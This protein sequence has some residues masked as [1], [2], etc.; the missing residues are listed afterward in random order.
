MGLTAGSWAVGCGP[1]IS[2][3]L[4][5]CVSGGLGGKE[6]VRPVEIQEDATEEPCV[7]RVFKGLRR[8]KAMTPV[9]PGGWPSL[10][11]CGDL[12]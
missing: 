7:A 3:K 10:R 4:G 6:K 11:G 8:T 5:F 2:V 1:W 9:F 12:I